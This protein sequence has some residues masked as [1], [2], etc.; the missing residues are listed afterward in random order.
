M[1]I[2][3]SYTLVSAYLVSGTPPS[4]L[5]SHAILVVLQ[6]EQT[7]ERVRPDETPFVKLGVLCSVAVKVKESAANERP[8]ISRPARD[9][10]EVLNG[11]AA[12]G[13]KSL[14]G[15]F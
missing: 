1:T 13:E 2:R 9:A 12:D 11:M 8:A 10:R 14:V 7:D 4:A 6:P 15:I 5:L 3:A